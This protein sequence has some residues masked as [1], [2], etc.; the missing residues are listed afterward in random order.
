MPASTSVEIR[1]NQIFDA[2]DVDF[3]LPPV[4]LTDPAY[5]LPAEAGNPLYTAVE[6]IEFDDLTEGFV[7]GDGAFEKVMKSLRAHLQL[8]YEKG[9]ITGDQYAK[10]Y[11]DMTN[12]AMGTAVQ[13]VMGRQTAY[14][15]T[16][17]VREQTHRAEAETITARVSLETAKAQLAT[18]RYQAELAEAQFVLTKV[19]LSG[20][21]AKFLLT[22]AQID[23]V[24]EQTEA[25]HAQHTDTKINGGPVTGLIQRQ[26]NLLDQQREAF[27]RDADARVA[28]MYLDSW[29]V[30][31]TTDEGT[32]VPSALADTEIN[33]V[34]ERLRNRADMD[35][36]IL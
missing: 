20:E 35:P 10:A 25:A 33:E 7:G 28:K 4:T 13:M 2:L 31:R 30:R 22:H 26:R 1:A 18:A 8:E 14:W 12:L 3:T 16:L 15:Q 9:R 5:T 34:M 23:M 36:V 6:H 19:Q 24:L 17:L 21:D 11:I 27:I 29:T 32:V